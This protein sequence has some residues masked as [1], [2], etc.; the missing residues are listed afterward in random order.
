MSNKMPV[1]KIYTDGACSG[2]PGPGGYGAVLEFKNITKEISGG[3]RHTTNNRMELF[4]AIQALRALKRP[5]KVFVYTDSKYV[6]D[7][8]AHWLP[9]W[10]KNNWITSRNRPVKNCDLWQQLYALQQKHEISWH[11]IKGHNGHRQNERADFLARQACREIQKQIS[12]E[13]SI[14]NEPSL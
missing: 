7:G 10:V 5:C 14:V 3:E 9:N 1:V 12:T 13:E 4:A 6:K 8:I 11:W 2:N